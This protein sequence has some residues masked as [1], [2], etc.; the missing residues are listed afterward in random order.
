MSS[1]PHSHARHHDKPLKAD[2][3]AE[4]KASEFCQAY[5]RTSQDSDS[6]QVRDDQRTGSF[7]TSQQRIGWL[8]PIIIIGC[9]L[10]AT[11]ISITHLV[12]FRFLNSKSVD[13][14]ISQSWNNALSV[15][16]AHAFAT[17]LTTSASTAF[18][19]LL[20]RYLRRRPLSVSNIDALF[21][22]NS[23]SS[24]LYQLRI[25]KTTPLL[26][27]FGL[28]IPL[29]SIATIFPPGSIRVLQLAIPSNTVRK[30]YTLDVDNRGN[31][32][33][34]DFFSFA[35]FEVGPDGEYKYV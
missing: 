6:N 12:Y 28:L 25:L 21:S 20:W 19:Q 24:N 4:S 15:V 16:F 2:Q 32:S 33:S 31:G 34:S 30:V 35:M 9:F 26:W 13:S 3:Q 17:T 8:T 14:T 18:T 7:K 29:I 5:Q 22:L 10:A 1:M 11:A 23:R 27:F